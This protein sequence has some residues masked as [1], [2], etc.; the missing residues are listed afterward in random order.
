MDYPSLYRQALRK[1]DTLERENKRLLR[2]VTIKEH[3]KEHLTYREKMVLHTII[4]HPQLNDRELAEKTQLKRSTITAIKSRLK[5]RKLYRKLNIPNFVALGYKALTFIYGTISQYTAETEKQLKR[6][7]EIPGLY[8]MRSTDINFYAL[9]AT[10]D[11]VKFQTITSPIMNEWTKTKM[12][13]ETPTIVHFIFELNKISRFLDYGP[14]CNHVLKLGHDLE[15][16]PWEPKKPRKK[17]TKNMRETLY[18]LIKYPEASTIE[19][20]RRMRLSRV[21]VSNII[22]TLKKER[23]YKT[24]IM[25]DIEKFNCELI[26]LTHFRFAPGVTREVRKPAAKY[27]RREPHAVLKVSGH[28]ETIAIRVFKNYAEQS[29]LIDKAVMFYKK[30]GFLLDEPTVIRLVPEK[31]KIY[32]VDFADMVKEKLQISD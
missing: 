19:L 4:Q 24:V 29:E 9:Y 11:L 28:R 22:K 25:P 23:Y 10:D 12:F 21:T 16:E 14:I 17:L 31:T 7:K 20:A 13:K 18:M 8:A 6:L 26:T 30:N 5:E 32:K 2:E 27:S 1:I 15:S 3:D